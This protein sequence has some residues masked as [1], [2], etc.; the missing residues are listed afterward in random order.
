MFEL[1]HKLY[2]ILNQIK[3]FESGY[4]TSNSK[5]IIINFKG[6]NYKVT[7]EE[8]G[9]GSIDEYIDYLK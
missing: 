6:N 2:T 9:D 4:T 5:A 8:L 7:I 1:I 3:G